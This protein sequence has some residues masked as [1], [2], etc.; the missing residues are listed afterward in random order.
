MMQYVIHKKSLRVFLYFLLTCII[1]VNTG[2]SLLQNKLFTGTMTA[3]SMMNT[4]MPNATFIFDSRPY[5]KKSP[6]RFDIIAF[7]YR[8]DPSSTMIKRIIGMPG[9][10]V[11]I[12]G[13]NVYINDD[14]E[15]LKEDYLK[16][17]PSPD[18]FGPYSVPQDSYFVLG[19]NR[20]NSIDSRFWDNKFVSRDGIVGKVTYWKNP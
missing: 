6:E 15:P 20:N 14:T 2:C 9:E 3:G 19:D 17:A 5:E 13:G 7:K 18:D 16:E 11:S 8:D 4:I 1:V 12:R 10:T